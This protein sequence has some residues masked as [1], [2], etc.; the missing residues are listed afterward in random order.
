MP[1]TVYEFGGSGTPLH[2]ALANGFPPHSYRPLLEPFTANYRVLS[3]PPRPLWTQ[4]PPPS[5]LRTW[6]DKATDLLAAF[7]THNITGVVAMGHSMG[8]V[9]T[10]I[11]AVREPERFR[12]VVLLDPTIFPPHLLWTFK[13]LR[14]IGL[15]G[16]FPLVNKALKRRAQF[17]STEEA[18]AYWRGKRLF[19]DWS[20]EVLRLYVEGLTQPSASG[21][22]GV[23]LAWSPQWEA[24]YYETVYTNSWAMVSRYP[25]QVPLLIIRGTT[26][27]T[28]FAS[29]AKRVQTRLPSAT[30]AEITG[31]GH[32]FPQSAPD[33]TRTMIS[34]WLSNH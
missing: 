19:T 9:A 26:S 17:T 14:M 7:D 18:F 33:Q 6:E 13:A 21:S 29:V 2:L 25:T 24:R 30:F 12:G 8:A 34:E 11:A 16:R 1:Q 28:F 20:D 23:E 10:L 3:F 4:P 15:E 31:H 32:L 22:G 27:N 5:S